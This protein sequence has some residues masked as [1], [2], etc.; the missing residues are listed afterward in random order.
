MIPLRRPLLFR[1]TR[2]RSKSPFEGLRIGVPED[3]F[4]EG[5]DPEVKEKVQSGIA[6]LEQPGLPSEFRCKCRTRISRP[7]LTTFSPRRKRARIWPD[8]MASATACACPGRR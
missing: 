4:G 8:T 5:L 6:L 3:Y 2:R 1:I 7:P